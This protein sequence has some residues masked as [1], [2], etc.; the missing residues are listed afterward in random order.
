MR[1]NTQPKYIIKYFNK[2]D[3]KEYHTIISL[4]CLHGDLNLLKFMLQVA[5]DNNLF[6]TIDWFHVTNKGHTLISLTA[7]E[8]KCEIAQFLLNNIFN[9]YENLDHNILSMKDI[10]GH[11]PLFIAVLR[12]HVE[13]FKLLLSYSKKELWLRNNCGE[14]PIHKAC[15]LN[16]IKVLEA[17]LN[18]NDCNT[19]KHLNATTY[20]SRRAKDTGTGSTPLLMSVTGGQ[21]ECVKM[22]CNHKN[23]DILAGKFTA[24]KGQF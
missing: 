10:N 9:S 17:M 12:D 23:V 18:D 15:S 5:R 4:I 16:K 1:S 7:F 13:I 14:M 19:S 11:T 2:Y 22:L 24:R 6:D 20:A 3:T 21:V 8:N